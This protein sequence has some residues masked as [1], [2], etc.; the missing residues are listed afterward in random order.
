MN[1]G[2]KSVSI[3]SNFWIYHIEK[4][5]S[6]TDE[7]ITYLIS[8]DISIDISIISITECLVL[9]LKHKDRI[10]EKQYN[11]IFQSLPNLFKT[12]VNEEISLLA[13]DLRAK[14]SFKTP[15]AIHISTALYNQSK[16][17]VTNDRQLLN[18][19]RIQK[20]QILSIN[21]FYKKFCK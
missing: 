3:D 18:K 11:K 9:P 5:T 2:T 19:K 6:F 12:K 15:D 4:E 7:I 10:V 17:F 20:L 8:E 14:Y 16:I 21:Q 1:L 13:A